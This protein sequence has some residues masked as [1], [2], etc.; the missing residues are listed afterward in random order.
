MVS[1]NIWEKVAMLTTNYSNTVLKK[2]TSFIFYPFPLS[3][4][5]EFIHSKFVKG[6]SVEIVGLTS[7][8]G[9]QI[10]GRLAVITGPINNGRYPLKIQHLTGEMERVS[11]KAQN[12]NPFLKP[13]QEAKEKSRLDFI[14]YSSDAKVRE[15]HGRLLDQV[16]MTFRFAVNMMNGCSFY[17]GDWE[18]FMRLP[19]SHQSV[20]M[21]NTQV[22]SLY[23]VKPSTAGYRLSGDQSILDS[24]VQSLFDFEENAIGYF[25]KMAAY[26]K[27]GRGGK[28]IIRNFVRAMESWDTERIFGEFWIA[29]ICKSGTVVVQKKGPDFGEP[30]L[31][32]VYLVKGIGSQ[33]GE[34]VPPSQLPILTRTTFLPLYDM[35]VYD[36]LMIMDYRY[37]MTPALKKRIDAHVEKAVREETL[38][39]CGESARKGLWNEEPPEYAKSKGAGQKRDEEDNDILYEPTPAQLLLAE[40]IIA[41]AKSHGYKGRQA[42]MPP[43]TGMPLLIVRKIGFSNE[44]NPNKIVGLNWMYQDRGTYDMDMFFFRKWPGYTLDELLPELLK[45]LRKMGEVPGLFWI[46]EKSLVKPLKDTLKAAGDK[47]GFN[48]TLTVEWY[49]PPSAEEE[50]YHSM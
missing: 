41:F 11:L 14:N 1:A 20:M 17:D 9:Q 21:C 16:L 39:Y 25:G 37:Q 2:K 33:V 22:F 23:R 8:R 24:T 19:R 12:I 36:G 49:P 18:T 42:G 15:G 30:E 13:E 48:E 10:N 7:E 47:L 32:D 43:Q 38:I 28:L 44:D 31:G 6:A 5:K 45:K 29:R 34:Q 4:R 50:A 35:L 26:E 3:D 40:K 27:D 46:C